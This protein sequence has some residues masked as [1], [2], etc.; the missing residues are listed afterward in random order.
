V[1]IQT[2]LRIATFC[3]GARHSGSRQKKN[4]APTEMAG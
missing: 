4:E 3:G 1:R 2:P